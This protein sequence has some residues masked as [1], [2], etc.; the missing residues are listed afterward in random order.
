LKELCKSRG[1]G[2]GGGGAA[3]DDTMRCGEVHRVRKIVLVPFVLRAEL[4]IT[5]AKLLA[6]LVASPRFSRP[7]PLA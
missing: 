2:G 5:R 4:G 6:T 1:G 7:S 3:A